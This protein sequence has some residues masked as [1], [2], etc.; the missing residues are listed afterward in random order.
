M[1]LFPVDL[2]LATCGML[3]VAKTMGIFTL[4][5]LFARVQLL[6]LL[7]PKLLEVVVAR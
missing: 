1:D 5:L 2:L 6:L 4:L 7:S 3:G